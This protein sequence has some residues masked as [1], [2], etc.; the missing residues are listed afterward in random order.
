MQI[1][2][3]GRRR[4]G[5]EEYGKVFQEACILV[6]NLHRPVNRYLKR[7][8]IQDTSSSYKYLKHSTRVAFTH[9]DTTIVALLKPN[10]NKKQ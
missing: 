9:W 10:F 8:K 1:R 5:N 7:P 3:V 2:E 4:G 6:Y